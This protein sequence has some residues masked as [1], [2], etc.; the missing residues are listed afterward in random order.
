MDLVHVTRQSAPPAGAPSRGGA[1]LEDLMEGAPATSSSNR[2]ISYMR[3]RNVLPDGAPGEL[4]MTGV[5]KAFTGL[6]TNG[7][8]SGPKTSLRRAAA[9][10]DISLTCRPGEFV[11]VV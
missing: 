10:E 4:V 11:V 3:A 9:L 2:A 1:S 7:V 6:S 8:K 5:S